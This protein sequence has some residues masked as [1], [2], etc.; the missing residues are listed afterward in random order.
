MKSRNNVNKDNKDDI[1]QRV[2]DFIKNIHEKM[3]QF[4]VDSSIQELILNNTISFGPNGY[5]PNILCI[6]N[7]KSQYNIFERTINN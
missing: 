5:G 7:I 6:P 3:K 1:A 4:D 2:K